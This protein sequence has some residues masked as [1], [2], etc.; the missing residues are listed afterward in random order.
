MEIRAQKP[1]VSDRG[2][3]FQIS[4][5]YHLTSGDIPPCLTQN[6]QGIFDLLFSFI[7]L[8]KTYEASK[9][10]RTFRYRRSL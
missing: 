1:D 2:I 3:P 10:K 6:I 4:G 8:N 9:K 7:C 5:L